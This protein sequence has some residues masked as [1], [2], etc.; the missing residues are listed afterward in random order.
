MRDLAIALIDALNKSCAP[1]PAKIKLKTAR[2]V[3]AE[4]DERRVV[5]CQIIR[6]HIADPARTYSSL[7]RENDVPV[8]RF[9]GWLHAQLKRKSSP[10]PEILALK[11]GRAKNRAP[12]TNP[13]GRIL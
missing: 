12:V 4:L 5:Y 10:H 3:G 8:D 7:C 2:L 13:N 1:V 9:K 11:G 6:A